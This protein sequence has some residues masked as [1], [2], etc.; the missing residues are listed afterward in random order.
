MGT[1]LRS[2]SQT[3]FRTGS[4]LIFSLALLLTGSSIAKLIPLRK[5]AQQMAL[6]GFSG[7]RLAFI[8]V[9]EIASAFLFAYPRTRFLGLLM[10]SAYLGGAIAAHV[11]HAQVGWQ[12]AIILA[13]VWLAAWLQ[14]REAAQTAN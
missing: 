1:Y 8:A 12:P 4:L 6:V 3:R 10:T 5:V 11:G 9:L 14:R 13:L 7:S 2:S